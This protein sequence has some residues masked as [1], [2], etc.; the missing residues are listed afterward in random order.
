MRRPQ[1]VSDMV[2]REE[3][4][5]W[6]LVGRGREQGL[7]DAVV[8]AHNGKCANR[9]TQP[10]GI[11]KVRGSAAVVMAAGVAAAS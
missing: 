9:L 5:A 8:I 3:D 6:Q 4:A 2:P 10:A 1:W 11:P 7:F